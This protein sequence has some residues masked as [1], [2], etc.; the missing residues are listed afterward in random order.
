MSKPHFSGPSWQD[1][2]ESPDGSPGYR[3]AA[4]GYGRADGGRNGR[5]AD[6]GSDLGYSGNG[7][8]R[9]RHAT[10]GD[11][12]YGQSSRGDSGYRS[13]GDASYGRNGNGSNGDARGYGDDSE[14][15]R[16]RRSR[17]YRIDSDNGYQS[18]RRRSDRY[19]SSGDEA[20]SD[21]T[22]NRYGAEGPSG[23]YGS[24]G[25]AAYG[26]GRRSGGRSYRNAGR[27]SS[28][29]SG[30]GLAEG[31][32]VALPDAGGYGG[33]PNG[34]YGPRGPRGP[35]GPGGPGGPGGGDGY[36]PGGWRRGPRGF[37]DPDRRRPPGNF[38]KRRG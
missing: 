34:P 5:A 27:T 30:T 31:G 6:A 20:D 1:K 17:A 33:G 28:Y 8:H 32:T 35:Y 11:S 10:N 19:S 21:Y 23:R 18:G 26:R 15:G 36:G 13:N 3:S 4:G 37:A 12:G 2:T 7:T 14:P 16:G 22:Q 29:R 38:Q 24:N 25:D 9:A